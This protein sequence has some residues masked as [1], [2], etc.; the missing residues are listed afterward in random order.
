MAHLLKRNRHAHGFF[1]APVQ[2]IGDT[3]Q[4]DDGMIGG[5]SDMFDGVLCVCRPCAGQGTSF[6]TGP[7]AFVW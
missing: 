5:I 3:S 1:G 6:L 2:D 4:P 7:T